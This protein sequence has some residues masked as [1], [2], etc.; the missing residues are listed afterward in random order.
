MYAFCI[1]RERS[2]YFYLCF[3]HGLKH[4]AWPVKVV[5]NAFRLN[6]SEYPTMMSLKNGFKTV[7]QN[8]QRRY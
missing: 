3:K 4:Q 2:G 5:P 7:F 6:N 8:Q 1:N